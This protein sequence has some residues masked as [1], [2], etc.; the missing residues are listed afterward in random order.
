VIVLKQKKI[1]VLIS[2]GIRSDEGFSYRVLRM[3]EALSEVEM[4]V[5]VFAFVPFVQW[6][7]CC[8]SRERRYT[9]IPLTPVLGLKLF[10][11][12]RD[13]LATAYF[14]FIVAGKGIEILQVE[15]PEPAYFARTSDIPF[16]LDLHGDT[17]SEEEMKISRHAITNYSWYL[18]VII[19]NEKYA[20][21]SCAGIISVSNHLLHE[22]ATKY[23]C[24]T[25][26][27]IVPSCVDA[28][29]FKFCSNARSDIRNKLGI[30]EDRIVM[31]Y[32][33]SLSVWQ[34]IHETIT[35]VSA[36]RSTNKNIFFLLLTKDDPST[37]VPL[38][39]KIGDVNIDYT[40][41]AVAHNE[42]PKY[43]SASDYGLLLR[44]DSI[45]NLVSSPTKFAEYIAAGVPVIATAHA[46]D[47]VDHINKYDT[48]WIIPEL[49]PTNASI[50]QLQKYL[51][52]TLEKGSTNKTRLYKISQSTR[53]VSF[54]KQQVQKFYTKLLLAQ[55]TT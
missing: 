47:A 49:P 44:E 18:D 5:A 48:G 25:M 41:L 52:S 36:L 26:Q 27:T 50:N 16:V 21:N 54:F 1:A 20:V 37:V 30:G 33:G 23:Q 10:R 34:M 12:L 55:E 28:D 6:L 45:V 11:A 15:N 17:V 22:V 31:T 32:I 42:V 51:V 43:L 2:G 19:R 8:F 7:K 9:L 24:A 46:G 53:S 3:V 29:L 13:T 38:L 14:K 40:V 4:D 39:V 35:L